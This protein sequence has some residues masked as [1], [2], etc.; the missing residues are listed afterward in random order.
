MFWTNITNFLHR[1]DPRVSLPGKA[2]QYQEI[3]KIAD[4]MYKY[5][6]GW[7][8]RVSKTE[9]IMDNGEA[10]MQLPPCCKEVL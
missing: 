6:Q 4:K 9:H 5:V 7:L 8:C 3:L 2:P 10:T 1:V